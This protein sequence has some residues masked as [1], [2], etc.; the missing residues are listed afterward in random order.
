MSWNLN[1]TGH[2]LSTEAERVERVASISD[3]FLCFF[4]DCVRRH[5]DTDMPRAYY[6]EGVQQCMLM[7]PVSLLCCISYIGDL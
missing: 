7:V 3:A 2:T 6:A 4:R 1:L 5:V